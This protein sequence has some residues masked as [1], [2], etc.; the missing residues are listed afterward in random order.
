MVT[1]SYTYLGNE[2]FHVATIQYLNAQRSG[3]SRKFERGVQRS[4]LNRCVLTTPINYDVSLS[5]SRRALL[6]TEVE[7]DYSIAH[8]A[9]R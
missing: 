2:R 5:T 7:S 4:Q 3:G 8:F 9:M 1:Y 6:L